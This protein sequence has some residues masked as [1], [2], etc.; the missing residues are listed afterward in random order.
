MR[1]SRPDLTCCTAQYQPEALSHL[2][3]ADDVDE[4]VEL[5]FVGPANNLVIL[6]VTSVRAVQFGGVESSMLL[7]STT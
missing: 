2:L 7:D 5:R 6:E 3:G 4:A 1:T